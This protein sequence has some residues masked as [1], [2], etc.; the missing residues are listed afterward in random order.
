MGIGAVLP[1]DF[2][3]LHPQEENAAVNSGLWDPR[4]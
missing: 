1:R 4:C 2:L 3:E